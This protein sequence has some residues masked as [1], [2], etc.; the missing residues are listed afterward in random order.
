MVGE[1]EEFGVLFRLVRVPPVAEEVL[2][3]LAVPERGVAGWP[4]TGRGGRSTVEEG[5]PGVCRG[6]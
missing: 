2:A 5:R 6:Q 1:G 3:L 4:G